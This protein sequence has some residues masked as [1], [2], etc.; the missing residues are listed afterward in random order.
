MNVIAMMHGDGEGMM[1]G[2]M[3]GWVGVWLLLWA[4][5]ALAL[6]VLAVVATVWLL[7]HLSSSGSGSTYGEVLERRYAAGEID[8]EEF[9]QRREDLARRS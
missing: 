1:G 9:L 3:S 8:R 6:L 4:V 7:K 2:S 5:L